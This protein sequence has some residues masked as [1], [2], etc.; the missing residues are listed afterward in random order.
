MG[1]GME[2]IQTNH[3]DQE[4]ILQLLEMHTVRQF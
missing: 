2:A 1:G 4:T 3:S